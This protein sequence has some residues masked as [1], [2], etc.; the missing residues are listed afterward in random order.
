MMRA[1]DEDDVL[2]V[3]QNVDTWMHQLSA[4]R[5]QTFTAGNDNT[6]ESKHGGKSL[7]LNGNTH[8]S[9]WGGGGD[10]F[11]CPGPG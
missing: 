9:G 6:A 5:L 1:D 8:C 2:Q 11:I 7:G 4:T 3:G 10:I